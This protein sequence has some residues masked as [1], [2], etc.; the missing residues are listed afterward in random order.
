MPSANPL[1][2]ALPATVPFVGPERLERENGRRFKA[3][4]GANECNFGCSPRAIEAMDRTA[5]EDVWK[6]SDSEAWDLRV[7]LAG[8]L[9][10][11]I[12]EIVVGSGIDNLLGV[13]VRIF[14]DVGD[15]IVTSAGAYPTFNYHVAGYGRRLVTVPYRDDKEDLDALAGAAVREKAKIVYLSNPDNPMGTWWSDAA[16][17]AFAD[18]LPAETLLILDEAYGEMAPP[19]TLPAIDFGRANVIRMRTFS[20]A[21]GLAGLRI[22]Y[23]FGPADLCLQYNKVRDH[24]GV[25]VMA[26]RAALAALEDGEWLAQVTTQIEAARKHIAAIGTSNG[27]APLPSATNF[28]TLDCGRD[29]DYA[30]RILEELNARDVFIRK[31]GAPGIDRC[32]RISCGLP[33]ELDY[34]EAALPEALKA[35]G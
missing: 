12:D 9:G 3:R 24:F 7:A 34:F 25:N 23:A 33:H 6:Y 29:G 4:L 1:V 27:L 17:E 14:A 2:A 5:R 16:V 26:Q 11:S 20:K 13:T 15:P 32:I 18:A 30:T 19:S 28:V 31:P 8:R 10:V 22:G 35:A 21:Y